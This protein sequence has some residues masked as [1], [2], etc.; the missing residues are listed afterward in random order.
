MGEQEQLTGVMNMQ[1]QSTQQQHLVYLLSDLNA[2]CDSRE[3]V[4]PIIQVFKC[5]EVRIE[6]QLYFD[7]DAIM[8]GNYAEMKEFILE[9]K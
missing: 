4:K 3:K 1:L 6:F 8:M 9:T 2:Y 7:G 5:G